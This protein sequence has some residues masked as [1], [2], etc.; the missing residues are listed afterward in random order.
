[1]GR[2]ILA[3]ASLIALTACAEDAPPPQVPGRDIVLASETMVVRGLVPHR[4]TLDDML[5]QGLLKGLDHKTAC[6]NYLKA[7]IK[8]VVKVISKMGISTVQSYWGAQ[9]FEAIG[10]N[11]ALIDKYFTGIVFHKV[12]ARYQGDSVGL[13]KKLVAGYVLR[14]CSVCHV[15]AIGINAVVV[16][17]KL[18]QVIIS[19]AHT[20]YVGKLP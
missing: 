13:H 16:H 3:L 6:K 14:V 17:Y 15:A 12:A 4:T 1:M 11:H 8:G 20:F 18:A 9:I 2:T 10:L 19:A 5:R 7:S